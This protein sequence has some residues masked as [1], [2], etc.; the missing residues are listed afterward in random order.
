VSE[1]TDRIEK[2]KK[3]TLSEWLAERLAN[4]RRIAAMRTGDDRDGWLE[5]ALYFEAAV[6]QQAEIERLERQLE[7]AEKLLRV[8]MTSSSDKTYEAARDYFAQQKG[9][10]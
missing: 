5:D 10:K 8:A 1:L 2:L 9:S 7:A 6:E 3:L 4:C